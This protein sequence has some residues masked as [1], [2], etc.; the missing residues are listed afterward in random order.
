MFETEDFQIPNKVRK[1]EDLSSQ[2][3]LDKELKKFLTEQDLICEE[4]TWRERLYKVG[5]VVIITRSDLDKMTVG[6][7]KAIIIRKKKCF[8]LVRRFLVEENFFHVFD[9]TSADSDLVFLNIEELHDSYP[10]LQRGSDDKFSLILHHHVSF[11][12]S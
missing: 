12:F 8:L 7:I 1:K 3:Q 6:V 9:S 10:L 2:V 11:S 4:L 5:T